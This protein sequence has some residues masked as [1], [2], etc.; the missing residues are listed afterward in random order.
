MSESI[1]GI[2]IFVDST[3]NNG[4]VTTGVFDGSATNSGI[5]TNAS[6]SGSAT[7]T[8]TVVQNAVFTETAINTLEQSPLLYSKVLRLIQDR[9]LVQ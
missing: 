5:T 3:I 1:I 7:N 4:T 9:L 2:G 8:G 6:F